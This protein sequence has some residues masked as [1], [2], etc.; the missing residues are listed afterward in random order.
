MK[1]KKYRNVKILKFKNKCVKKCLFMFCLCLFMFVYICLCLFMFVHVCLCL[2][3][4]CL[5]LFMFIYIWL[6][7]STCRRGGMVWLSIHPKCRIQQAEGAGWVWRGYL[8]ST[9]HWTADQYSTLNSR[10]VQYIEQQTSTV[11]WT[12]DQYNTLNSR[13]VQYIEQQTSTIHWTTD[14]YGSTSNQI[15]FHVGLKY[16]I[17]L[18]ITS[19]F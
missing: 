10:P 7:L 8:I 5:C 1:N 2:F 3:M 17:Y 12:T 19:L 4:F 6:S 9:V 15:K 14:Q 16:Q 13:Q 11:H 18:A